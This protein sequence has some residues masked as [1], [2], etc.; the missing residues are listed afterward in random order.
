MKTKVIY[1]FHIL[2]V[3]MLAW[4]LGYSVAR[5]QDGTSPAPKAPQAAVSGFTYQ[6]SLKHS[7][8]A[9]NASCQM[10][11][12]LFGSSGGTDLVGTPFT[13]TVSVADGLFSQAL[14]FGNGVF[15]GSQRWL[16][17]RVKCPSETVFTA[18]ERQEIKA[19]PYALS[20]PW[21]GI[22]GK[23]PNT[24]IVAKSG[25]DFNTITA[26]LNSITSASEANRYLVKVMP[27]VYTETVTM[28]QYVD[29]EGSG[30]LA[31]RITNIGNPSFF[32]GTLLGANNAEVRF[33][34][35]VN[36]GGAT[37]AVAIYNSSASPLLAN[38]IA[39]ASGGTYN[40]GVVNYVSS[41]TMTNVTANSFG[42]QNAYGV[43][44][45]LS[46]P[47]M[48]DVIV[49]AS[50]GVYNDGIENEESSPVMTNVTA[51]A[52]D[53]T[54][55]HGI[56]NYD[57]SPTM[58]NVTAS[59]TGGDYAYGI[60][61]SESSPVMMN[62][63]ASAS[64]GTISNTGIEND[65][66]S[67]VMT[68]VIAN[69]SGGDY[70]CGVC[71]YWYSSPFMTNV[72][73]NAIYGD[74]SVAVHNGNSSAVIQNSVLRTWGGASNYGLRN[75]ATSGSYKVKISN[76]QLIGSTNTIRNDSEFT[77]YV[78]ATLLDGGAV[79]PNGGTFICTGVYSET[80]TALN[81][82]CQ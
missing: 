61:N 34:T 57:S 50:G 58:T 35:V 17:V 41:P 62:V 46:S 11:F 43:S 73:A 22:S 56:D 53:G 28:E 23:P 77:T 3:V 26:A 63:R 31:T 75:E 33:L 27:G 14:D 60:G 78:G 72:F 42:G 81:S 71:N 21:S 65:G 80:Y 70:S 69:A 74:I 59:A 8:S 16:E 32:T 25:G 37:N 1:A 48:S 55:N 68:D 67:P 64:D 45:Y 12:R 4:G 29:I 18:L 30:E 24:L 38:V 2:L 44:N 66:S 36:T 47:V 76:S 79:L 20:A 7:G 15:D 10:A 5:G 6:G 19:S 40:Y 49:N 51:N 9:V 13:T 39:I 52:S 82:T 54:N